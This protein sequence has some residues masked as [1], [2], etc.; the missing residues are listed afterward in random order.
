MNALATYTKQGWDPAQ[1]AILAAAQPAIDAELANTK[2]VA[3][4]SPERQAL[5][6]LVALYEQKWPEICYVKGGSRARKAM[7]YVLRGDVLATGADA[8]GYD[9]WLVA[10]HQCSK[11][12][13]WCA[14]KDAAAPVLA[15]YGKLCCHRLAVALKTNWYGDKNPALLDYLHVLATAAN[16]PFIDLLVERDY[17]YHHEGNRARVAGFWTHGMS[18]HQRLAPQDIIAVTL[19]QFQWAMGEL[20][21]S[22]IDLPMKLPGDTDYYYRIASGEGLLLSEPVFWH[23]GRTWRMHD[24]ERMRRL[25]LVELAAHLDE[26]LNAPIAINLSRY[27][28]QRVSD[29]RQ[30]MKQQSMQAA[31]VW[32]ALPESLQLLILE[33]EGVEYAN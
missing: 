3:A 10:G 30:R 4:V 26:W 24:R 13:N 17:D 6:D 15:H 25:H 9:I 29:L 11:R 16:G 31:E 19:P 22:L 7:D 1:A 28:A 5:L 12:G 23:R 21:W 27:E 18:Q 33:N 20:D 2:P 14:C 8:N 32:A